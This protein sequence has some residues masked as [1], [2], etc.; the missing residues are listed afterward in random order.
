LTNKTTAALA[1]IRKPIQGFEDY[2]SLVEDL[3]FVFWEGP[4]QR[5]SRR[6]PTSFNDVNS[7]RTAL[8]H[9]VG[10]G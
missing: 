1:R 9:E 8:Q 3:Y 2:K 10:L 4:G 5:L 7:L 6:M